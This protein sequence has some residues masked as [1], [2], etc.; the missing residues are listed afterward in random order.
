[1]TAADLR[2]TYLRWFRRARL[3][4]LVPLALIALLQLAMT[5]PW[6]DV[7]PP[8]SGAG[9]RYLFIG[10]A[11]GAAVVGRDVRRSETSRG[12][13]DTAA[14]VSLS[15]RLLVYALAPAVI[16]TVLALMTRQIWD[17]YVLLLATLIA[18]VLL[19]PRHDQ[20]V[21]WSARPEKKPDSRGDA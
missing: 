20:W 6:W 2:S 13:M 14:L 1:M 19:F 16:G 11:I 3:V 15:W 21:A 10:V 12:P 8:S 9:A 18:L 4:L 17:F 5:S 7:A